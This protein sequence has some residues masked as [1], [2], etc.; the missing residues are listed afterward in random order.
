MICD[1]C[2]NTDH[3][4][5]HDIISLDMADRIFQRDISKVKTSFEKILA[6]HEEEV[7]RCEALCIEAKENE[8]RAKDEIRSKAEEARLKLKEECSK[9]INA[10]YLKES[11]T[12]A[13]ITVDTEQYSTKIR[14]KIVDISEKIKSLQEVLVSQ[15]HILHH[16]SVHKKFDEVKRLRRE[17]HNKMG[18]K[19]QTV[20]QLN[21]DDGWFE[22]NC[23]M[24]L[25][26]KWLK[27]PVKK[28]KIL[29]IVELLDNPVGIL[30]AM[31]GCILLGFHGSTELLVYDC[32]DQ[33]KKLVARVSL[34]FFSNAYQNKFID[35]IFGLNETVVCI[36]W[37]YCVSVR[38]FS[39]QIVGEPMK[40]DDPCSLSIDGNDVMYLAAGSKGLWRSIDGGQHW[41]KV[42]ESPDSFE[43]WRCHRAISTSASGNNNL[44]LS[45]THSADYWLIERNKA[46]IYRL[47]HYLFDEC[48]NTISWTDID[49]T[50]PDGNGVI[51]LAQARLE[52]YDSYVLVSDRKLGVVHAYNALNDE[53]S[54][55]ILDAN[56]GLKE[57]YTISFDRS[58]HELFIG[59]RAEIQSFM[60][61]EGKNNLELSVTL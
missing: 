36:T 57:P 60:N 10:I 39:G 9:L 18:E 8:K 4:E 15:Q 41:A 48:L 7:R 11:R 47:R 46:S 26:S 17:S 21:F 38:K 25:K 5:N 61:L 28:T 42:F 29:R 45:T 59:Q 53:Y 32:N 49:T 54:R 16:T 58:Q 50:T 56:D 22:F 37:D 24:S 3:F 34:P 12:L 51:N 35:A 14:C 2:Y 31:N 23:E 40:F 52:Y 30:S 20:K 33:K 13:K 1:T 55:Q 27:N 44:G 6:E 19:K 43:G